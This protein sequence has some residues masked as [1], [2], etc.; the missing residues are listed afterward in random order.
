MGCDIHVCL[1]VK[2]RGADTWEHFLHSTGNRCYRLFGR[3]AGVRD[4]EV[5]P[6]SYPRGIPGDASALTKALC[7]AVEHY[8]F[9]HSRTYLT[10]SE[11]I[12]L[13]LWLRNCPAGDGNGLSLL[14]MLFDQNRLSFFGSNFSDASGNSRWFSDF[15]IVCWF[16]N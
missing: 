15:R 5:E 4:E 6:I 12:D 16:D 7:S 8:S 13:E 9:I 10:A 2:L 11:L 14:S 3:I 1:E